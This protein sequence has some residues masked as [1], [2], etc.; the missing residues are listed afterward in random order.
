MNNPCCVRG[1]EST[2]KPTN[3][4]F[5]EAGQMCFVIH[6]VRELTYVVRIC[7]SCRKSL[8][9]HKPV[10]TYTIGSVA[11]WRL[12]TNYGRGILMKRADLQISYA[13]LLC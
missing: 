13:T 8:G 9:G 12:S 1:C 10:R 2:K 11:D 6:L 4:G 7:E 5:A 3:T